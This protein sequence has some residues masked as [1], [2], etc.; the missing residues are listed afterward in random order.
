MDKR[1]LL[2]AFIQYGKEFNVCLQYSRIEER[3]SSLKDFSK[4]IID[5]M[6]ITQI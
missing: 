3:V 1:E 6:L 4:E 5:V 2:P